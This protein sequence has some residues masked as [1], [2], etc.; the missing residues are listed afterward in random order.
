MFYEAETQNQTAQLDCDCSQLF[1]IFACKILAKLIGIVLCTEV[2]LYI[3]VFLLL[4]F[5]FLKPYQSLADNTLAGWEQTSLLKLYCSTTLPKHIRY[6]L[7][8]NMENKLISFTCHD[9]IM[10]S[11]ESKCAPFSCQF[12]FPKCE[13]KTNNILIALSS[14]N[15]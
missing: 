7:S 15:T 6:K 13:R 2:Q 11:E 8:Q 3:L 1:H 12:L 10:T 4:H 9:D 14:K 5:F